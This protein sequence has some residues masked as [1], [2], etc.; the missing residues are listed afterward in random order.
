ME[1]DQASVA[2][3]APVS[4]GARAWWAYSSYV[5]FGLGIALLLLTA[6]LIVTQP[7]LFKVDLPGALL[8]IAAFLIGLSLLDRLPHRVVLH[9]DTVEFVYFLSRITLRWDQLTSPTLSGKQFVTFRAATGAHGVWGPLTVTLDQA[10]AILSHPSCP[11]FE[12]PDDLA[13]ALG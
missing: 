2:V 6:Y 3:P 7:G 12:L 1:A 13:K 9:D 11:S 4:E 5:I 8:G 10:R